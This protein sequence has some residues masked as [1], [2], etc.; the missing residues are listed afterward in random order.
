MTKIKGYRKTLSITRQL[1]LDHL[2]TEEE[3]FAEIVHQTFCRPHW[4]E[5]RLL[6]LSPLPSRF[7]HLQSL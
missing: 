5:G 2:L 4:N 3:K 6:A 7:I 1:K